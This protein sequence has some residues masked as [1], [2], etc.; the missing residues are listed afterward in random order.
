MET[1]EG[2]TRRPTGEARTVDELLLREHARALAGLDRSLDGLRAELEAALERSPV[3]RH[4]VLACAAAIAL[5][6]LGAPLLLRGL[7]L[8]LRP[9][10]PAAELALKLAPGLV[11]NRLW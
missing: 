5:G 8:V 4:P 10:G 9:L 1:I 7:G 3:A 11:R 2:K 6:V